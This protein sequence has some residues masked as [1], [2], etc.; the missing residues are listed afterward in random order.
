MGV[1]DNHSPVFSTWDGKHLSTNWH[2][3]KQKWRSVDFTLI[4]TVTVL[5]MAAAISD[6]FNACIWWIISGQSRRSA[7]TFEQHNDLKVTWKN[8]EHSKVHI[9]VANRLTVSRLVAS[10]GRWG[11]CAEISW[12][13][14]KVFLMIFGRLF[15]CLE[16]KEDIS[17]NPGKYI[18]VF[19]NMVVPQNGWWK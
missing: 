14:W 3:V 10:W 16:L 12:N 5:S 9:S 13:H 8:M 11:S 15:R 6:I 19:P 17:W 1:K 18:W 7:F 4:S 2:W